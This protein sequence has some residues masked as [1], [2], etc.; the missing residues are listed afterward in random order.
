M[1]F[2]VMR[3]V[4]SWLSISSRIF[5][6]IEQQIR[7]KW[8]AG[9]DNS[10]SPIGYICTVDGK[11]IRGLTICFF[12]FYGI[13]FRHGITFLYNK[14]SDSC[15]INLCRGS[16]TSKAP[17]NTVCAS[18]VFFVSRFFSQVFAT[19]S[20]KFRKRLV[21]H[22]SWYSLGFFWEK[23]DFFKGPSCPKMF[24]FHGFFSRILTQILSSFSFENIY[25]L[26]LWPPLFLSFK[27]QLVFWAISSFGF[28]SIGKF[29]R[30]L[31]I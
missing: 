9:L 23:S 19:S 18:I 24:H 2:Y 27:Q 21:S 16:N 6:S 5:C 26:S 30:S 7:R 31:L 29:C 11:E 17:R 13:K 20:K 12:C 22:T 25:I 10:C 3:R 8:G 15:I 1:V 28:C 4:S 14:A